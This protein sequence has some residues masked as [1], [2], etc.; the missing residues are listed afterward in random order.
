LCYERFEVALVCVAL[1]RFRPMPS[2][3]SVR[4][5]GLS[6][7]RPFL[8]WAGGKAQLLEQFERLLPKFRGQ[9]HEPFLGGGAMFFALRPKK[10]HLTDVN[11]ELISCYQAVRDRVDEVMLALESHRYDREY[12]YSVREIDPASLSPAERAAR[13]I[14]L[15]KTAFNGLYRVNNRGRFNVPFGRHKNPLICDRE[16]LLACS[17]ALRGAS[18]ETSHF[19]GVL[20]RARRGDFVYFDPPYVPLSDTAYFTA[21]APGGFGWEQQQRLAAVF[22]ELGQR[23]VKAM[24]SNSDVPQLRELYAAF[25]IE[26]VLATR[27]INSNVD[28]RG[29]LAEIVV[30][31]Y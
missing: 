16:N 14:F 15:N 27:R 13:T 3:A 10:A 26:K 12:F 24:L 9:Y 8:K 21:Y 22:R 18:I 20:E 7:P 19:S 31:N 5:S 29:K 11:Q 4:S 25:R 23:G 30:L 2:N 1:L 6:E 17:A 28:G